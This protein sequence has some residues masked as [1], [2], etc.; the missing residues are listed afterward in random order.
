MSNLFQLD[1]ASLSD[2]GKRKENNED[3]ITFFIPEKEKEKLESGSLFVLADG[4]GGASRGEV[5]SKYAADLVLFEYYQNTKDK[6]AERLQAAFKKASADIHSYAEETDRYTKM[7]TTMVAAV[8]HNNKLIVANVGDSRAYII[9]QG[10]IKQLTHDHSVVAEMVRNGTMTEEE[11]EK[12]SIRNRL[13]RSIG[14]EKN[15]EVDVFPA[16][17]LEIGDKIILCSDGLSR[18][19]KSEDLVRMTEGSLKDAAERLIR[20]ANHQ[21]GVD[22]IS[23]CLVEVVQIAP[24]ER[25]A[26]E[27]TK[28]PKLADWHEAETELALQGMGKK[29]KKKDFSALISIISIGIIIAALVYQFFFKGKNTDNG[30]AGAAESVVVQGIEPSQNEVADKTAASIGP[31]ALTPSSTPEPTLVASSIFEDVSGYEWKCFIEIQS[32][33]TLGKLFPN[34]GQNYVDTQTYYSAKNC[35]ENMDDDRLVDCEVIEK[36]EDSNVV[37][38]GRWLLAFTSNPGNPPTDLQP[39][40]CINAG[41]KVQ[42]I[43][44]APLPTATPDPTAAPA[45]CDGVINQNAYIFSENDKASEQIHNYLRPG[46]Q[47]R[48]TGHDE[49]FG[50]YY[51][52]YV[53]KD[54]IVEGWVSAGSIDQ[55][56]DCPAIPQQK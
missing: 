4:V 48:I 51:V 24:R 36:I 39:E 54:G 20:F 29:K 37:S 21:G 23:V 32:G 33:D 30:M 50:F 55:N 11:A 41:G 13:S 49:T 45:E 1:Y 56:A 5:A 26:T 17:D 27:F 9:R 3:Y 43:S 42:I 40:K 15:V 35:T 38:V 52:E 12:S 25:P 53:T 46:E 8:I 22:N 18:Y 7:A 19:A 14:G 2:I 34:F 6:P 10:R 44:Y 31:S 47:V 16:Y 28:P